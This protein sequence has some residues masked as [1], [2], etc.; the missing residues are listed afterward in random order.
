MDTLDFTI[1]VSFCAR[2]V[3]GK[4]EKY[5]ILSAGYIKVKISLLQAVEAPRVA[6]CQGS[7]IT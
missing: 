3:H 2:F 5:F 7:H 6:R 4:N 1:M